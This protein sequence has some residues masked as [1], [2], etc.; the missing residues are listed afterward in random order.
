MLGVLQCLSAVES[1]ELHPIT[2]SSNRTSNALS[3]IEL[4]LEL[5][6]ENVPIKMWCRCVSREMIRNGVRE[7]AMGNQ[8]SRRS[9]YML[10][11]PSEKLLTFVASSPKTLLRANLQLW[12]SHAITEIFYYHSHHTHPYRSQSFLA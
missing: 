10:R 9:V 6:I 3:A 8:S 2:A 4:D 1:S 12:R 7:T 11:R 5:C